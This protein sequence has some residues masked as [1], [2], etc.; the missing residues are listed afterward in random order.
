MIVVYDIETLKDFFLYVDVDE[1]GNF[2]IF[3]CSNF[4]NE[5]GDYIKHLGKL[6]GQIGFNNVNF[7]AQVQQFILKN[8]K[9]LLSL[10]GAE[11]ATFIHDYAQSVVSKSNNNE[12]LDFRETDFKI[13]Q[14]DLFR[15]FHYNNK[16]RHCSLKWLQ[17]SMDWENIEDMPIGHEDSIDSLEKSEMVINYCK[18]DCLSTKKFY[19]ISRGKTDN[20]IYKGKDKLQLRKDIRK[21][22]G[23]DCTNF[24]DVKIGD[25]INKINYLNATELSKYDLKTKDRRTKKFRFKDCFPEYIDFQTDLLKSFIKQIGD[26]EVNVDQEQK[27]PFKFFGTSYTIAKGGLHSEDKSRL[28][29]PLSSQI[30]R[31]CDVGSMYPNAIRKR[32]IYP[33]A[34]GTKWLDGYTQIIQERIEAKNLYEKT[35]DKKYE[36]F[37]EAFKL[38]LN[39]GSFGKFQDKT[40]WQYSPKSCFD[41]TIG[42]QIDLLMLIEMF[43]VSGIKVISANTDGVLTLFE[44]EKEPLYMSI[45]KEWEKKVGNDTLGNLEYSDYRLFSQRSVNDYIAIKTNDKPKHKG[46]SFTIHHE[47]HKNKSY[48]IV[49][50]ALNEYYSKG[51]NPRTFITNHE[52]IFD[53][54]AGV[55]L[56]GN[57]YLEARGINKGKYIKKRLQRTN[58]YYISKEGFKLIKCN[59]DGREIQ[60]DSGI[61]LSTVY[62]KHVLKDIKEYD[63]NYDFYVKQVYD[64]ISEIEPE[65]I[66]EKFSQLSLFQ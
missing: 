45:C 48:R 40:N 25:E 5:L 62:N 13:K 66:N 29:R 51:I 59:P 26:I 52:N 32:K 37:S 6:R 18:N 46:K 47:F 4:K 38:A 11:V 44:K 65:V 34:L 12:W 19:E 57:W 2:N 9:Y 49:P 30:L 8:H 16:A 22:F 31:D 35:K 24:D 63:L 36:S 60:L 53:F 33:E 50:L 15:V 7:D 56:N 55:R 54:C 61:W 41:V 27:F 20:E 42:C 10:S 28:I 23:F 39:G 43:E 14:V 21:K 1:E 17:Y 3:Q 58:R 64:I